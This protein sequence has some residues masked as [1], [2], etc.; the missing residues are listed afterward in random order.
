MSRTLE[1]LKITSKKTEEDT[2]TSIKN[3]DDFLENIITNLFKIYDIANTY[4]FAK[5]KKQIMASLYNEIMIFDNL[6]SNTRNV[7]GI[8]SKNIKTLRHFENVFYEDLWNVFT[9][10]MSEEDCKKLL[11]RLYKIQPIE[12]EQ[13]IDNIT[14][15]NASLISKKLNMYFNLPHVRDFIDDVKDNTLTHTVNVGKGILKIIDIGGMPTRYILYFTILYTLFNFLMQD[16][17]PGSIYLFRHAI[18]MYFE[19]NSPV[20]NI[21][22]NPITFSILIIFAFYTILITVNIFTKKINDRQ[23]T[24]ILKSMGTTRVGDEMEV[25]ANILKNMRTPIVEDERVEII[26]S[27]SKKVR[28]KNGISPKFKKSNS[29]T[30][31]RSKKRSRAF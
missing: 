18:K 14:I 26:D 15:Q 17:L 9:N 21:I 5:K 27:G 22:N 31:R 25:A 29:Q 12:N 16:F 4:E 3:Y 1:R 6:I 10:N 7:T 2:K 23:G 30:N 24:N 13:E 11:K 19:Y 8:I 20:K 28:K